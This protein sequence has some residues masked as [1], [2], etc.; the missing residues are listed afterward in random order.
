MDIT[1]V[2]GIIDILKN[3]YGFD[4]TDATKEELCSKIAAIALNNKERGSKTIDVIG[5]TNA[6]AAFVF[7]MES[8]HQFAA[9]PHTERHMT[10]TEIVTEAKI[11]V[12]QQTKIKKESMDSQQYKDLQ[13]TLLVVPWT[14]K[15]TAETNIQL[16]LRFHSFGIDAKSELIHSI[17]QELSRVVDTPDELRK[18]QVLPRVAFSGT[19]PFEVLDV[20]L[21]A[22]STQNLS[23][24]YV[25]FIGNAAGGIHKVSFGGIDAV[26][27][28]GAN[29]IESYTSNDILGIIT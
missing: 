14:I 20:L 5:S 9:V 24:I 17:Y 23:R 11:M 12:R 26:V 21:S 15:E 4:V 16:V 18:F 28:A 27:M 13:I 25:H 10:V 6:V 22:E 3:E 2:I 8:E 19:A 29:I 1:Q 7:E